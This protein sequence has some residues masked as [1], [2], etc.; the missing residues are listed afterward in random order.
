MRHLC[1]ALRP[2]GGQTLEGADDRSGLARDVRCDLGLNA[3][4]PGGFHDFERE[5]TV[6][7]ASDLLAE[8]LRVVGVNT[9]PF[10]SAARRDVELLLVHGRTALR[11]N[12]H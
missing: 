9:Q 8:R 12:R 7:T 6:T 11:V 1:G 3:E 5:R 4:P 10:A 2:P